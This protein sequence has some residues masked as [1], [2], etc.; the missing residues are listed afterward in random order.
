MNPSP[1]VLSV[2]LHLLQY[3]VLAGHLRHF[4]DFSA[5][6]L[7]N[8]HKIAKYMQLADIRPLKF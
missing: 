5:Q 7:S 3:K 2:Y 4:Q 6:M 8:L 1:L